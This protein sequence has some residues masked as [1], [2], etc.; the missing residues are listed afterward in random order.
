[1]KS[2]ILAIEHCPCLYNKCQ[3]T[4][5]VDYGNKNKHIRLKYMTGS[6][7]HNLLIYIMTLNVKNDN[8]SCFVRLSNDLDV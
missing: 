7:I 8:D 4:V 3:F 6:G 2:D 1:M 5:I